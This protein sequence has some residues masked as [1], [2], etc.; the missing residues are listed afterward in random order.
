M[1]K[2]A[3]VSGNMALQAQKRKRRIRDNVELYALLFPVLLHIFIFSY[4]PLYGI[5][6]AFQDYT[7]G[8]PFLA[9]DGSVKWVGLKHFVSFVS[10]PMF[11]RIFY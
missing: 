4:I 6:I 8:S 1:Q 2:T 11:G 3:A 5:L 9:F 10:S 7:P